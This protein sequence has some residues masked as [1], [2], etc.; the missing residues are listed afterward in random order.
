MKPA[1]MH[2]GCSGSVVWQTLHLV[3]GDRVPS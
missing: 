1:R 3:P 2:G